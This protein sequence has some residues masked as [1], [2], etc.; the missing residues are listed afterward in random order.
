MDFDHDLRHMRR[1]RDTRTIACMLKIILYLHIAGG[2]AALVSMLVPLITRKGGRAHRRGGWVF[3]GGMTV[4]SI[5]ALTLSAARY[6]LDPRPEAQAFALFL[7]YIAILTG[8]GVS[9]GIRALR[10]RHRSADRTHAWDVGLSSVLTLTA[11]AMAGYGIASDH[12][13]FAVFSIIGL[14]NG[15]QGVIYWLRPHPDRM[16]WWLRHMSSMLGS[17]IAATTAFLVVNA[18]FAGLSRTSFVV[19]MAPGVV[20]G[21]VTAVWTRYYKRKFNARRRER[22]RI[23]TTAPVE[24][25]YT[26][27]RT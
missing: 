26:L 15:I 22:S 23:S 7:F 5:T 10:T 8:E 20:G 19:W 14:V 13:L 11:I 24:G 4:V 18:P 6:F 17:C 3:V 1:P 2:T 27:S 12:A 16:Y 9:T 25:P 21:L